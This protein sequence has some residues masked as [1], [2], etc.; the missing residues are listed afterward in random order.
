MVSVVLECLVG[1]VYFPEPGAVM[2]WQ[3]VGSGSNRRGKFIV[4]SADGREVKTRKVPGK[5]NWHELYA[6]GQKTV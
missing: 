1:N 4:E 5:S 2:S 6:V 3:Y